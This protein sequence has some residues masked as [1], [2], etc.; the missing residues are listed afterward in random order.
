MCVIDSEV[1]RGY[2]GARSSG[3]NSPGPQGPR[4]NVSVILIR[5]TTKRPVRESQPSPMAR[6]VWC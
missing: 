1:E 3:Q 4:T 5:N 6:G 2:V